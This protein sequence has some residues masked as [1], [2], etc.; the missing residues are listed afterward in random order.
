MMTRAA[1]FVWEEVDVAFL[2][3][4]SS[5]FFFRVE[6]VDLASPTRDLQVNWETAPSVYILFEL[7]FAYGGDKKGLFA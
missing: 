5:K 7:H 4:S 2:F 1:D 6:R 3:E